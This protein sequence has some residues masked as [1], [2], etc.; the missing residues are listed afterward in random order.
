MS[1]PTPSIRRFPS[2]SRR[3]QRGIAAVEFA[4]VF[5]VFFTVFYGLVTFALIFL[6]QHSLTLAAAEGARSAI[7]YQPATQA[8][9]LASRSTLACS[10][11]AGLVQWLPGAGASTS[12]V[13][14]VVT[15]PPCLYD[16]TL[17]CMQVQM[18]Y[19]YGQNPLVPLIP[20]AVAVLPANLYGV[21]TVQI[22]PINLTTS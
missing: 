20:F 14:C 21:A 7:R 9:A 15:S 12:S 8:I 10:T 5:P 3:R 13:S 6:A 11:A 19:A 1:V 17:I 2:A 22:N 16:A 4:I 18:T